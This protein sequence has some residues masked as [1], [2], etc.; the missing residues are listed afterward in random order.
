MDWR[1]EHEMTTLIPSLN[2]RACGTF[3]D[4]STGAL[5]IL[6]NSHASFGFIVKINYEPAS[7]SVWGL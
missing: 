6:T 5:S 1:D 3:S 4:I 7:I 2:D